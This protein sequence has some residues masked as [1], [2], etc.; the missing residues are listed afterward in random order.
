MKEIA[1]HVDA[2]K[3]DSNTRYHP[4]FGSY[5]EPP[6][7]DRVYQFFKNGVAWD[8]RRRVASKCLGGWPEVA[9]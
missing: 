9:T 1:T 4:F 3:S 2:H 7:N 6:A 8:H 5:Q